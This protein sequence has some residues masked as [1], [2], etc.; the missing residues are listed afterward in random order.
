MAPASCVKLEVLNF[1]DSEDFSFLW[2]KEGCRGQNRATSES[3]SLTFQRVSEKDF[4]YYQ[5]EVKEAGVVVFTVY[6]AL[7]EEDDSI[8]F[9]AKQTNTGI[10]NS[11]SSLY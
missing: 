9:N 6:R 11:N 7:Y 4:G 2:T 1:T 8:F 5:C 10:H 3:N